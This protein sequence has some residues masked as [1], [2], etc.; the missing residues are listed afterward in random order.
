MSVLPV[1]VSS[2]RKRAHCNGMDHGSVAVVA[3]V[4]ADKNNRAVMTDTSVLGGRT[5]ECFL[6]D[7]WQQRPLLLRNAMPG[8]ASP[9]APEDLLGLACEPD[10]LARIILE[11]EGMYPWEVRFGPFREEDFADLP[12][13]GWTI[14][15]QEVDRYIDDVRDLLTPFRFAPNW[16]LDDIQVSY[17]APGGNAGPHI[18]SYDVFLLQGMGRREWRIGGAPEPG[19]APMQE[20]LD[21]SLLKGFTVASRWVLEPGDMLYLPP[22]YAHLGIAL[23]PCLTYS[24]GFRAPLKRTLVERYLEYTASKMEP[25]LQLSD[26]GR[27]ASS[28]PGLIDEETVGDVIKT[29]R[30]AACDEACLTEW[31]GR[32][33]TASERGTEPCPPDTRQSSAEVGMA[34]AHGAELLRH[35]VPHFAYAQREGSTWLFACGQSYRLPPEL[36]YAGKLLSG[37]QR[38]NAETLGPRLGDRVFLQLLATLVNDGALEIYSAG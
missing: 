36:M 22:R 13:N 31:F 19:D 38:L 29:I 3:I 35:A 32:F 5:L 2:N 33:V 1:R 14:L 12:R 27:D 37:P 26:R 21:L 8:F 4:R 10:A 20:D 25:G 9:I 16:R 17:A 30:D 18:D 34:L 11:S 24:I 28:D 23:E 6:Q 7:Y 15:V